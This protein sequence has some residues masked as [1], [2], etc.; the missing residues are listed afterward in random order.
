MATKVSGLTQLL[1]I[2]SETG[3]KYF[4][5][6]WTSVRFRGAEVVIGS[7]LQ[8]DCGGYSGC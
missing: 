4:N 3:I 1:K 6:L 5:K 8:E 2:E 7:E